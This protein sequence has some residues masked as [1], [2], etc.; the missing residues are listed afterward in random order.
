VT[1]VLLWILEPL[2]AG[3]ARDTCH[4]RPWLCPRLH[5]NQPALLTPPH[6]TYF[7]HTRQ[8]PTHPPTHLGS[9]AQTSGGRWAG[10]LCLLALCVSS[11]LA[12]QWARTAAQL[13]GLSSTQ[14]PAC[15]GASNMLHW[16]LRAHRLLRKQ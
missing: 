7:Q 6:L 9:V 15:M 2:T 12:A 14:E 10:E 5:L 11:S 16:K 1:E 3:S 8:P 13:S 4:A